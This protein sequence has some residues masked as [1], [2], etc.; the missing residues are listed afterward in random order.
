MEV[1]RLHYANT[2]KEWRIRVESNK[3]NIIEMYDDNFLRM[4]EFYLAS[5]ECAF[6]NLGHVFFQFQL[7]KWQDNIPLTREYLLD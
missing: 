7:S 2:L 4:W 5:A 6:R 1:L 3:E